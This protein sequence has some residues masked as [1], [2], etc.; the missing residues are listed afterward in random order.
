MHRAGF[1]SARMARL[2]AALE[3]VNDTVDVR[4]FTEGCELSTAN[5]EAALTAAIA[6]ANTL[7]IGAVVL[8]PPGTWTMTS[9][10]TLA[11][12]GYVK[13][14]TSL[15]G[16]GRGVTRLL[17]PDTYTGVCVLVDGYQS[18]APNWVTKHAQYCTIADLNIE[19]AN[20]NGS[21]CGIKYVSALGCGMSNVLIKGF[22]RASN[23][24]IDQGVGLWIEGNQPVLGIEASQNFSFRDVFTANCTTS[25]RTRGIGVASFNEYHFQGS[26]FAD[27]LLDDG[28][29]YGLSNCMFQSSG[30]NT[31]QS[32]NPYY[33]NPF[34]AVRTWGLALT[35]RSGTG[36]T[37][38]TPSGS[39]VTL[40][41]LSGM[42]VA[43]V[44]RWILL[45]GAAD[46]RENGAF[47]IMS[48]ISATSVTIRKTNGV[49]AIG[50][51]AWEVHAHGG[52]N[53]VS[54]HGSGYHEGDIEAFARLNKNES[55]DSELIVE[56]VR[57]GNMNWFAEIES[58]WT[59]ITRNL[60]HEP[61]VGW[62]KANRARGIYAHD[63]IH[64]PETHPAKFVLD[65]ASRQ[66][67]VIT[68]AVR[69]NGQNTDR[70]A[71]AIITGAGGEV[72]DPATGVVLNANGTLNTWTGSSG[73]VITGTNEPLVTRRGE[74]TA[75]GT[76]ATGSRT[77]AATLSNM[78][79]GSPQLFLVC[80]LPAGAPINSGNRRGPCLTGTGNDMIQIQVASDTT[81]IGA[82]IGTQASGWSL[83]G[84]APVPTGR[85]II[86]L[87]G[88]DTDRVSFDG[89]PAV[90]EGLSYGGGDAAHPAPTGGALTTLAFQAA[91]LD[92]L[93]FATLPNCLSDEERVRLMA[94]A[95][96]EFDDAEQRGRLLPAQTGTF[97]VPSV[98]NTVQPVSIAAA[99]ATVDLPAGHEAGD[100]FCVKVTSTA[101]GH[102]CTIDAAGAETIDGAATLVLS[103]DY[104]VA[105]LIS[106]GTNWL[107][108]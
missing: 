38:G 106:D 99:N 34:H 31:E 48:Y 79:A 86:I 29:F 56:G 21:A 66:N 22:G 105:R 43:D 53:H 4:D 40:T 49:G 8:I 102:T 54:I 50:T 23:N 30:Y 32:T 107:T 75:I 7:E 104:A 24:G 45:S 18:D 36:A 87:A 13:A 90:Y 26:H 85:P 12:R 14:T 82:Y 69:Y 63:L 46:P 72:F 47:E 83:V 3:G 10:L 100:E 51:L 6:Y 95:A 39:V 58:G 81:T 74:H 65:P 60:K 101:S 33:G 96:T 17:W 91:D 98:R 42:V 37:A 71:R 28:N 9:Q 20:D 80:K 1:G 2:S 15:K 62:F 35:A 16:A 89:S 19:A 41:G 59:V 76:R 64:S 108:V 93:Y 70:T 67:L 92:I 44:G 25:L 77:L 88:F 103:T 94:L 78:P 68:G 97:T 5:F 11:G 73:S 84:A 61:A 52:A 55:G 27:I 57:A